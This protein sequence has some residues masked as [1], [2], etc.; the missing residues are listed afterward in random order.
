M[1]KKNLTI[2]IVVVAVVAAGGLLYGYNRWRQEQRAAQVFKELYGINPEG[3]VG[4][5]LGKLT[6]GGNI[7]DEIAKEMAKE[8]AKDEARQKAEEAAEAAKTPEDRYNE[9][10]EAAIIG[11]AYPALDSEVKPKVESV[12]G[13]AKVTGYSGGYAGSQGFM[14]M[15]KVPRLVSNDDMAKLAQKF[16][17]EGFQLVINTADA[18]G[19]VVAL[20]KENV[21]SVQ[22]MYGSGIG[23]Q[24]ISITFIPSEQE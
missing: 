4:G 8:A 12:F 24:E 10:K 6:G 5:L 13:K 1:S 7:S 14:V 23:E 20:E 22:I 17:D 16:I 19:G 21:A 2:L 9:T 3:G 11:A 18:E 15:F